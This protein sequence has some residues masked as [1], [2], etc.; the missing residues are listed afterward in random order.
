MVN[1][2]KKCS[3]I[4][5][6]ILTIASAVFIIIL[7]G[8]FYSEPRLTAYLF[9]AGINLVGSLFCAALFFGCMNQ[10]GNGITDL[11]ILIVLVSACF[12]VIEAIFFTTGVPK[13]RTI[14][15]VLCLSIKLIDLVMIY[16][17]YRYVKDTLNFEG[18]L[19][20]LAEK[21]IPLMMALEAVVLLSNIIHPTTFFLDAAGKYHATAFSWGED[22]YLAVASVLAGLLIIKSKNP[23]NQKGAAMTFILFPLI[24]YAVRGGQFGNSSQYGMVL[25]SLVIMYCVIFIDKSKTLASTQADLR[26]ATKIQVG[27]LPPAVP[28][29]SGFPNLN[30]RGSM[31][32]A[33][34]VGGDF[35]DYFPIDENRICFLIADVSGKGMPAAL[36]MMTAKTTIKD[37]AL[38][39]DST[40]EIFTAVNARLCEGNE[41]GMFATAWIGIVDKRTMTL[42]YTN[43]GHNYPFLQ[44]KGQPCEI[45]KKNHGLF[46]AGMEDTQYL[47]DSIHLESGDRLLLYTDG[48]VEAHDQ[49]GNLYGDDRLKAVL[50]STGDLPGEQVLGRIGEDVGRY[51]AGVPQFDDITM[52]VLTIV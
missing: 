50:D 45:L 30:L 16:F 9:D 43:A 26:I 4:I 52:V 17:F 8:T 51:A 34:E 27:A 36:F 19:A 44:R 25:M 6:L 12:A 22:I 40:S 14:C 5:G 35:Y 32:T 15:F 46:L 29:F 37:Y 21:I 23:L 28:E 33:K 20:E 31:H 13:L 48:V 2:I 42:Q 18:S 1:R 39:L 49:N 24:E 7:S 47:E 11:K 38:N 3:A 41:E 10:K